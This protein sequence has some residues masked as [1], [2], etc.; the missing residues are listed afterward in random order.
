MRGMVRE[1]KVLIRVAKGAATVVLCLV[2]VTLA[3]VAVAYLSG[4][5]HSR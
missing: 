3:I 2:A 1:E 5:I 4:T